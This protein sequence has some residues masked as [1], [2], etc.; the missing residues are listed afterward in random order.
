MT[1]QEMIEII[2][3]HMQGKDIECRPVD[4]HDKWYIVKNP[5]W[6]FYTYEYRVKSEPSYRP[7]KNAEEFLQAYKKHIGIKKDSTETIITIVRIS[8]SSITPYGCNSTS[9]AYLLGYF[10][11]EDGS[12]CGILNDQE[13]DDR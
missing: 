10:T 2:S 6:D 11:W 7:Y 5:S 8:D 12:V 1:E 13:D 4:S 3:A 9:Y